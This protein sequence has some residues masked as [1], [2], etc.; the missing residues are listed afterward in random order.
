[1]TLHFAIAWSHLRGRRRQTIASLL[2]VMLGVA[3]F[4]AVSSLMRGS[5]ADFIRRLVDTSPHVTV[6]DEYRDSSPQPAALRYPEAAVA[7]RGVKP[8]TERRGIRQYRQRL[9]QIDA[10]PGVRAAPILVGQVIF[11]FAGRDEAVT[12]SGIEPARM[13]GVSTIE[14]DMVEGSLDA[15]DRDPNGIIIG[16]ALAEKL[17]LSMG[18]T[19]SVVSPAGNVRVMKI[20]ALF[21]TGVVSYDETQT[22]AQLKRVQAL[23][24]RPNAANMIVVKMDDAYTARDA[25]ARIERMV[26][27]K[28]ISWQESSE[29]I[30][31]TLAVRNVIMYSVVAAILLVASFG[32]Y[33]VISSVIMEKTRDIAILKSM[34]FRA[35]DVERIFLVEG[36][37][38]GLA[39]SL[40]GCAGGAGLIWLAGQVEITVPGTSD[41]IR[42]PVYWGFDQFVLATAFAMLSA[43]AAAYLPARRGARVHPVDILRGAM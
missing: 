31:S 24:N 21:R 37:L 26:G 7:V 1:M 3:F 4:L 5:E 16:T 40:L 13:T 35:G 18:D 39:G 20:V 14:E 27:Y 29:N 8:L 25:A 43:V 17:A 9:A 34:G 42:L 28:S 11:S 10:V 6:S 38:I 19:V 33:N 32:I 36:V 41:P 23:L 30:L 22:F 2:G 12:L 15:V